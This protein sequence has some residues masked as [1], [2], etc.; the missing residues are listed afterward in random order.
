[1]LSEIRHTVKNLPRWMRPKRVPW[2][3]VK[4]GQARI[5]R[6]LWA[7]SGLSVRGTIL[8]SL[9]WTP[10]VSALAAGNRVMLNLPS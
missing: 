5:L 2:A 8:F 6:S 3:R 10:L 7:L 4:L 1:M 9:R